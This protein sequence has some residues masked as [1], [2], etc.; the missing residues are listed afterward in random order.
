MKTATVQQIRYAFPAVLRLLKNGESIA[1]TSRRK[2]VATLSPPVRSA[3]TEGAWADVATRFSGAPNGALDI[4][5][6]IS[7]DRGVGP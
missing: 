1:I 3:R 5:E 4:V 7:A 2:I 6:I